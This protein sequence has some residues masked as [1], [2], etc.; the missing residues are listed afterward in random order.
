MSAA[1]WTASSTPPAGDTFQ[2]TKSMEAFGYGGLFG[3]GPGEGRVKNALPDAHADFVF[4]VAGEEFGFLICRV[5]LRCS[6]SSWCAA[7]G[8]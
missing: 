3:R 7:C 8:G 6:A 2:I 5:I 4:A 1:G